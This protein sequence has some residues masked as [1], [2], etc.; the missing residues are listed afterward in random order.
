MDREGENYVFN[1]S[2]NAKKGR[3]EASGAAIEA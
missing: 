3:S 1:T 2:C